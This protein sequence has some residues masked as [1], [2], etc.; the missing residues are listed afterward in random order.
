MKR[1]LE[2]KA[3]LS[4]LPPP[5][6]TVTNQHRVD[7]IG[8]SPVHSSITKAS[9]GGVV[10]GSGGTALP[11]SS[12]SPP[13]LHDDVVVASSSSNG[14]SPPKVINFRDDIERTLVAR[15]WEAKV[16]VGLCV[17]VC[18]CVCEEAQYRVENT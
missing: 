10:E 16:G 8:L 6:T 2:H 9:D 15:R 11:S 13:P 4:S 14:L 18:V 17:C 5:N 12:S 3:A 1:Q 7:D